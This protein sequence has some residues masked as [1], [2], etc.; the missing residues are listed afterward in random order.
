MNTQTNIPA[1]RSIR[2]PEELDAAIKI[3]TPGVWVVVVLGIA[4]LAVFLLWAYM[5]NI[6]T[7]INAVAWISSE[8]GVLYIPAEE[9]QGV[10]AT[11]QVLVDGI[12]HDITQISNAPI[13][14]ATLQKTL[15]EEAFY[16]LNPS[17]SSY[18]V[19]FDAKGIADGA[20]VAGVVTE[21]IHPISFI[22]KSE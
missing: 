19:S 5:G 11:K 14:L 16:R 3:S 22:F 9:M 20:K 1:K 15:S 17:S 7:K 12:Y 21:Q 10:D 4:V 8:E 13:P 18:E 6:P 2:S